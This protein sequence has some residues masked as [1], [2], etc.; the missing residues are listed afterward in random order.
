MPTVPGNRAAVAQSLDQTPSPE[1]LLMTA[2]DMNNRG[3]LTT[4]PTSYSD[5][6]SKLTLPG[7]GHSSSGKKP[8]RR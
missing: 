4:D 7:Y 3:Q 5:P 1:Q 6:K 8:K 2:A